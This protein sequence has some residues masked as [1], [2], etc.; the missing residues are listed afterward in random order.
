MQVYYG[1]PEASAACFIP[2]PFTEGRDNQ[3][4]APVLSL[5]LGYHMADAILLT[6]IGLPQARIAKVFEGS[7]PRNGVQRTPVQGRT[8]CLWN[9]KQN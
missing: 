3:P 7:G 1:R 2:N 8:R 5:M 9:V 4:W 6:K